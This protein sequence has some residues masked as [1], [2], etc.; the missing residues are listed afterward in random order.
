MFTETVNYNSML[1]Y[2]ILVYQ[3]FRGPGDFKMTD[4]TPDW[5]ISKNR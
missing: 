1:T 4:L 5:C 3:S 2:T